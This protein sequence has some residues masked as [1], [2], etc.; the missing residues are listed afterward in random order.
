MRRLLQA[1]LLVLALVLVPTSVSAAVIQNDTMPLSQ[2]VANPCTGDVFIASGSIHLVIA[3]TIDLS[4]GM[5]F[6]IDVNVSNVTGVGSIT[7]SRYRGVGGF[8]AEFNGRA[9][10][11]F[12]MTET[13]VFGLISQGSSPNLVSTATFHF[14]VNANGTV[15]STVDRMR[16]ACRG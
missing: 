7:G 11:P 12:T 2:E 6:H 16:I 3:E 4:G 15:T 5:H 14:T 10:Y 9:P 1:A 13:A 8:W